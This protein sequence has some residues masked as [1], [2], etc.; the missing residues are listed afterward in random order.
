MGPVGGWVDGGH[1]VPAINQGAVLIKKSCEDFRRVSFYPG[2]QYQVSV[3]AN[4]VDGVKLDAAK[5]TENF[6]KDL[7]GY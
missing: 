2:L 1:L 4:H 7:F 5:S 3:T 6:R